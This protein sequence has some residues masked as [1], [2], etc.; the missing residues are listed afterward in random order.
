MIVGILL[1]SMVFPVPGGPINRMLWNPL[2]AISAA[3]LALSWPQISPKST[4]FSSAW[5]SSEFSSE[6][7]FSFPNASGSETSFKTSFIFWTPTTFISFTRAPS[8]RFSN[9][10]IQYRH[11][12][13]LARITLGST[14]DT[15][16][17]SPFRLSSP[18]TITFRR[19]C[20]SINPDAASTAAATGRSKPAPSFRR[21]AGARF[22]VTFLGGRLIPLFFNAVRTL[23]CA[24]FTWV[25]GNPT[26]VKQGRPLLTSAST[27][28]GQ[29]S[30]P[31][32]AADK[33]LANNLIP[34]CRY[35]SS[36]YANL[37]CHFNVSLE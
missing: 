3:L 25:L 31:E 28:T 16:L 20:G 15:L 37:L 13:S 12:S 4:R 27:W 33:T 30:I 1:A 11:P 14:P 26:I 23:S 10:M 36:P 35:S 18:T 21:S 22:T 19:S 5:F 7:W 24:S 8:A 32:I 34:F 6:N 9:G 2:T 17:T 29:T